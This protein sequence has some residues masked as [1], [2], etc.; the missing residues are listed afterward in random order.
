MGAAGDVAGRYDG[1]VPMI[2]RIAETVAGIL[3]IT[4][5]IEIVWLYC[6]IFIL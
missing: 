1:I 3:W 6:R 5:L 2:S 4:F